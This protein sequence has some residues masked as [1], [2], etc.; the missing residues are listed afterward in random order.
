M[1]QLCYCNTVICQTLYLKITKQSILTFYAKKKDTGQT[2]FVRN[3]NL[4]PTNSKIRLYSVKKDIQ[5]TLT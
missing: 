2:V 4:N 1:L 3:F 5:Q